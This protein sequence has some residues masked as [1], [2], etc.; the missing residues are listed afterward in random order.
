M[1]MLVKHLRDCREF[2]AGDG[3]VLRELLH[4]GKAALQIRYSLAHAKVGAGRRT[5]PHKLKSCEA[6]YMLAGQGTMH[7]D[8]ETL[9]VGPG[10]AVYIPP[11][12]MQHIEN[13]GDSDLTFLC[14]VDPAWQQDDEEVF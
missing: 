8:Q 5:K 6:Y 9:A 1:I 7:I 3:S 12:S 14:I 13:T 10:C 11:R 2:I 4:P